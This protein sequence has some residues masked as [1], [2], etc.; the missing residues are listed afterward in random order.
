MELLASAKAWRRIL[1]AGKSAGFQACG[2]GLL[3][4][5]LYGLTASRSVLLGDD[6]I[7]VMAAYSLG[8]AHPPGYPLHS[9]LGWLFTHLPI[10]TVEW[11]VHFLSGVFGALT[12]SVL[13]LLVKR[14]TKSS[15]GAW[16]AALGLGLSAVF[17]SQAINAK[18]VYTLNTLLF[19]SAWLAAVAYRD[20]GN[21]RHLQL[22]ALACG[23]GLANHWPL[24]LLSAPGLLLTVLPRW[25]Q[26]PR[27]ALAA[28][29]ILFVAAALPYLWLF[30]RSHMHP[31]FCFLGPLENWNDLWGMIRRRMYDGANS[32]SSGNRDLLDMA[33][34]FGRQMCAQFTP[35]GL[36]LVL[37]GLVVIWRRWE[38]TL[39]AGLL[40]AWFGGGLLLLLILRLDYEYLYWIAFQVYP[41]IPY[42]TMAVLLGV[43]MSAIGERGGAR[44]RLAAT[45]LTMLL[46]V[47]LWRQNM[48]T[49]N[50]SRYTW[51]RDYAALALN[52]CETNAVLFLRGDL[53]TSP[54]GEMNLVR[55]LRRDVTLIQNDGYGLSANLYSPLRTTPEQR[56]AVREKFVREC[57]R[58]V[59]YTE[60]APASG[61]RVDFGLIKKVAAVGQPTTLAIT[62]SVLDFLMQVVTNRPSDPWTIYHQ[63]RTCY[64]YGLHLTQILYHAPNEASRE[65]FRP[66]QE[67]VCRTWFGR[68]GMLCVGD[69]VTREKAEDLQRWMDELERSGS[70]MASKEDRALLHRCRARLYRHLGDDT[71]AIA[72]LWRC[73]DAYPCPKNVGAPQELA[74]LLVQR[75]DKVGLNKMT[76]RYGRWF[77]LETQAAP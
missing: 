28:L 30:V 59:Y 29:P 16:A 45:V 48:A 2:V 43:A 72:E 31:A 15:V 35:A 69:S 27:H 74:T 11:R 68:L 1:G 56:A 61:D 42:M 53:D 60:A 40:A 23:L 62:P 46:A 52:L 32:I 65:Y 71:K 67:A 50:Q 54:I 21:R 8:I 36:V 6:G 34:F 38:R 14:L 58:P 44:G 75:K 4:L 10:S 47:V 73:I 7:F 76:I 41:L 20:S 9:A 57:G 19:V 5:L 18:S 26:L 49:N 22:A 17:W 77:R 13:W 39:R 24:F 25:R 37:A 12:C 3:L 55:G 63:Q 64:Q 51:G 33:G 70:D 66:Y